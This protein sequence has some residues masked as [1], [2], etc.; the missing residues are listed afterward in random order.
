MPNPNQA[1]LTTNLVYSVGRVS[2][3][4]TRRFVANMSI[5]ANA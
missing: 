4:V 2:A 3:S 5:T 1:N